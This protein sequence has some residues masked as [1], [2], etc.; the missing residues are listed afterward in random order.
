[1]KKVLVIGG[2]GFLG[3]HICDILTKKGYKVFIFDIINSEYL[4]DSQEMILGDIL[5]KKLL[6]DAI[7][8]VDYVYHL[9]A[10]ADI[11]EAMK[12]P[13]KAANY[14][15]ISTLN[16]LESCVK[17][18]V[19]RFIFSSSIYVYSEHGSIYKTTK[20]TCELFIQDYKRL[21]GLNYT[22]LRY[23]S[24][25]GP[26]ANKFNF[27]RNI[28]Q[29]A[30]KTGKITRKG[31]GSELRE[32]INVID[33]ANLSVKALD[34]EFENEFLMITGNQSRSIKELI[35]IINE[36][37]GN[38]LKINY[39]KGSYKGHYKLTP[40]VF[41]P[42]IA[43]KLVPKNYYDLGQGILDCIHNEHDLLIKD[44]VNIKNF[45]VNNEKI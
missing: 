20:Q 6:D 21:H 5:D 19:K 34:S 40:Y 28:V 32:Y 30:L 36:I 39:V 18:K 26:R 41:K 15:I 31:D 44:G 22:V 11:A 25:Y 45:D 17:H 13:L 9:A 35:N 29:E 7:S 12:N 42:N 8:K 4:C 1:M 10:V 24:L 2:S 23:G 33:A 37:F 27:V 14:N 38:E 43:K 16:I 3:S